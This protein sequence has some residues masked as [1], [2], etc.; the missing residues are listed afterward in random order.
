MALK[1]PVSG[2]VCIHLSKSQT[3]PS[4]NFLILFWVGNDPSKPIY[5]GEMN[6]GFR[7]KYKNRNKGS[8]ESGVVPA[9]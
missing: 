4:L 1:T 8:N 7:E 5:V 2:L 6:I 3:N 9:G